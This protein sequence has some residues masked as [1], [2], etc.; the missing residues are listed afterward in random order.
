MSKNLVGLALLTLSLPTWA[1]VCGDSHTPI[2][3]VQGSGEATPMS[4]RT[5]TVEGIITL[6]VRQPGGFQGFY[7]QQAAHEQDANPATSEAIL[8]HT[9]KNN[10]KPGDRV[11]VTGKAGEYYGLT[12][13]SQVSSVKVCGSPGL[14]SPVDFHPTRIPADAREPLESMLVQISQPLVVVDTWNLA[15][16]GEL[17]LAPDLQWTATQIRKPAPGLEREFR[18]QDEVRVLLDDG[19]R[20]QHPRPVPWPPGGLEPASPVRIGGQVRELIGVLDYR[21]GQ[22]RLQPIKPPVFAQTSPREPAPDRHRDANLRVVSLNLSNLFN[23]DGQ[24]SGFPTPRGARTARAFQQQ[25]V[26]LTA[27]VGAMDPDIL[28]VTELENDGYDSDSSVAQLAERLGPDWNFVRAATDTH[29]DAIRNGLL[30][31]SGRVRTVGPAHLMNQ[32]AF[33]RWH[34]PAISQAFEL[35]T[36]SE[37][38]TVVGIHLK[39]KRCQSAPSAQRDRGDGQGCYATARTDAARQL[40]EQFLSEDTDSR[41]VL[42]AG[43]F[44]A[45]A[46]EAPLQALADAGYQDLVRSFHGARMATFRYHGRLGTLDYHLANRTATKRV[47]AS[48]IW[49]VNA[50]EPRIFAY[51]AQQGLD[52]PENYVWRASDHNPVITDLKLRR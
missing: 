28:V 42:L 21:F 10:G 17:A 36:G 52:L 29:K 44:N 39:S 7:L 24:G 50:E 22:W 34:R 48:H 49:A 15:R 37:P 2:A 8:I 27:Q 46:V 38:I 32:G 16:Y 47:L 31:R 5:V 43:D 20:R 18:Q 41:A 1:L 30:Y 11:R 35:I 14:P 3:A 51:D 12:S 6:D 23:G 13:L 9:R 4:G 25:L 33:Q 45:Y 19:Q 40:A 26:R